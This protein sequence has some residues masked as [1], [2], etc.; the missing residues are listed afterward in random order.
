MPYI[1]AIAAE[2]ARRINNLSSIYGTFAEIGAGQEVVNHFFKAGQ[3]SLTV[4]KSMSAYDMVF[5]DEIYGKAGRYVS[6]DRLFKML[7]HEYNLLQK[8]L[9]KTKGRNTRFFTFANTVTTSTF[10]KFKESHHHGWMGVRFQNEPQGPY[11]EMI[12][13][14]NLFDKTRLQQYETLGALGVNL[15]YSAFFSRKDYKNIIKSLFA[16]FESTRVDIGVLRCSGKVFKNLDRYQINLEL[17]RQGLTQALIFKRDGTNVL[18]ADV[19]HNKNVFIYQY[20]SRHKDKKEFS[21]NKIMDFFKKYIK[22]KTS[23]VLIKDVPI[24]HLKNK[25]VNDFFNSGFLSDKEFG[26]QYILVSNFDKLYKLKNFIR[27]VTDQ[28]IYIVLSLDILKKFSNKDFYKKVFMSVLEFFSR[29][30]DKKTILVTFS[31]HVMWQKKPFCHLARYLEENKQ[32]VY[33]NSRKD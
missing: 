32:M 28:Y 25:K 2:K 8:R 3:A 1:E 10:G 12:I 18:P 21:I 33:M 30:C 24:K 26:D 19:L 5:S 11:S 9:S 31:N 13:H 17:I 20:S 4:A 7:D 27:K 16:N 29:L 23:S 6:E 15:I 22:N 14:V